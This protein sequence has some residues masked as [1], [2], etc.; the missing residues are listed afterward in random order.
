MLFYIVMLVFSPY[1]AMIPA[2]YS[3]YLLMRKEIEF[4]KNYWNITLLFLFLWAMLV[5]VL[6]KSIMSFAGAFLLLVYLS[7]QCFAQ[8]YF[9]TREKIDEVLKY[10]VYLTA[11][12]GI[13]GIAEYFAFTAYFADEKYKVVSNFGNPNMAAGW[14]ASVLIIILYLKKHKSTKLEKLTYNLSA[15]IIFIAFI[16]TKSSGAL[17]AFAGG[18]VVYF[19]AD[20]LRNKKRLI[21]ILTALIIGVSGAFYLDSKLE[22]P[23]IMEEINGSLVNRIDL[24]QT[25]EDMVMMKPI[26][27]WGL[28]SV[29]EH[30]AT[31]DY[32]DGQG[33]HSHNLWLTLWVSLG[34]IGLV[35]YLIGRTYMYN[36]ILKLIK[37]KEKLLALIVALNS[38][39]LIQSIVDVPLYAPQLGILFMGTTAVTLNLAKGKIK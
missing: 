25:A 1:V 37:E 26:K 35:A 10:L 2:L 31:Y 27:G 13:N 4:E 18:L 30:G 33:I 29:W 14:F 36:D 39:M 12:C 34:L 3:T 8:S 5:A 24:W 6:N 9:T 19:I 23:I 20:N 28:L 15:L 22:E 21:A 16:L 32:G 38:I 17:I 7:V 11:F